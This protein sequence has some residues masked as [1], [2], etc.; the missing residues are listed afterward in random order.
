MLK[1]R[2]EVVCS[3]RALGMSAR[4]TRLADLYSRMIL[5]HLAGQRS[6]GSVEATLKAVHML[7][8]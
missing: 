3:E 4:S 2:L 8:L 5:K 6:C 1:T 7:S